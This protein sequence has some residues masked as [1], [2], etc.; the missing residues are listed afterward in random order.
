MSLLKIA[1]VPAVIVSPESTV[2]SAIEKMV[3][4]GV[5][6]VVVMEKDELKGIFTERDVMHR[7]AIKCMG[8]DTT[9]ISEVMNSPVQV[10]HQD[11]NPSEALALMDTNHFR[12]LPVVDD[13]GRVKGMLS[14][15][16]LLHRMVED[17]SQELHA[18]DSYV[19]ADGIGG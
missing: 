15:R 19:S 4:V 3:E 1:R 17:I 12:H 8:P 7:V 6:A 16:H 18:L 13:E 9:K 11:T 5:G 10:V 2:L 14:I